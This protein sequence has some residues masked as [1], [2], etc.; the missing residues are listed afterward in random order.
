MHAE[1][2][3]KLFERLRAARLDHT[4]GEQM[5]KLHRI[6]VLIIDDVALHPLGTDQTNDFYELVVC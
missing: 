4:H 3:D 6:Q 2:A 5:R 1:G